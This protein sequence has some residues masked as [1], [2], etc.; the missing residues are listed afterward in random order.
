MVHTKGTRQANLCNTQQIPGVRLSH[1]STDDCGTLG[2][3]LLNGIPPRSE[4]SLH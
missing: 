4:E 2:P 1:I 3:S